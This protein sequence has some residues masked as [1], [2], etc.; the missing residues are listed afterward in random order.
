MNI[1]SSDLQ[2]SNEKYHDKMVISAESSLP[3]K[4]HYRTDQT[5]EIS[6]QFDQ[7]HIFY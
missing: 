7:F 5:V 2:F 1:I 3:S 6:P 4:E